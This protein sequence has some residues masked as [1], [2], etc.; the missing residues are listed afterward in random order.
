VTQPSGRQRRN[1]NTFS[2]YL[3]LSRGEWARLRGA[4]PLTL[5]E[6][7]L[8]TLRGADE[9]VSLDEVEQVYLPL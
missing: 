2:P 3:E 5:S 9:Y 4:T 7:D 8:D 6:A 1:G